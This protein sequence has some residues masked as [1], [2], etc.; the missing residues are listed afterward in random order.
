[1]LVAYILRIFERIIRFLFSFF[2][3]RL[4]LFFAVFKSAAF[5]LAKRLASNSSNDFFFDLKIF[6]FKQFIKKQK[7]KSFIS[8]FKIYISKKNKFK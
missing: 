7:K 1:M 3:S 4:A 5:K 6:Y 8:I 2:L